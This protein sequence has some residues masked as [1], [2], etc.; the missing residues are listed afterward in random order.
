MAL[1]L[2][3]DQATQTGF[4]LLDT[5]ADLD[6]IIAGTIKCSGESYEDKAA[7][8]GRSLVRLIKEHKPDF[9]AFEQPIR[10]QPVGRR[11]VKFMGETQEVEGAGSGLNAVISSNQLAGAVSAIIGAYGIPFITIAPVTWR[12]AFLGF[13][14]HKGWQRKDWKKAARDRCNQLKIKVTNDDMADAVG[15]A[16]AASNTQ[17]FKML[18]MRAAA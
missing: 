17:V 1:I 6:K 10:T 9:I 14:T 16:F 18:S 15:I 12:K 13:G 2:G 5:N 11:V 4:A 7:F 8:L 3:L